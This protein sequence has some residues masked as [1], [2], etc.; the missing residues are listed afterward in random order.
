MDYRPV[1][2]LHQNK[3]RVPQLSAHLKKIEVAVGVIRNPEGKILIAKRPEEKHMGGLWEFPGGKI[4]VEETVHEALAR[5]LQ[6]EV[7][8]L[9]NQFE[10]LIRIEHQYPDKYVVLNVLLITGFY[11][12]AT[13]REGQEIQWVNTD[14]LNNYTFPEANK[15]VITALRLPRQFLITGQFDSFDEF[16]SRL[17]HAIHSGITHIQIRAPWLAGSE[18]ANLC[19]AVSSLTN[20]NNLRLFVNAAPDLFAQIPFS[21]L[22]LNSE[23]LKKLRTRSQLPPHKLLSAAC[24]SMEELLHA[25]NLGVDFVFYSPVLETKSHPEHKPKG[26]QSLTEIC[27]AAKI[28]VY[29][30]GGVAE[31]DTDRVVECGAQGI[32]AITSLWHFFNG[33][34]LDR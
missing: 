5:E 32:A 12:E 17:T 1:S 6:E 15:P 23:N 8:I 24:H 3:R 22:H 33:V 2:R 9:P 13:G 21:N 34:R 31:S 10:N 11:G 4:E 29:A 30:L 20:N 7:N 27:Q 19:S 26:W 28:P 16:K 18:Y 14:D 25:E